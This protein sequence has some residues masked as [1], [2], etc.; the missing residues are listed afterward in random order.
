MVP[1]QMSY[2]FAYVALTL[3]NLAWLGCARVPLG[4]SAEDIT[5]ARDVAKPGATLFANECASCHGQRGEGLAGAPPVLGAG[6]LP[7]YPRTSGSYGQGD[8]TLTDPQ[9]LQIKAQTRPAGA[10]WRDP[11]KNAQDLYTFTTLHLPRTRASQLAEGDF[12]AIVSFIFAAQGVSLPPGGIGPANA[13]SL[14]MPK[15]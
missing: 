13:P 12:W 5:R 7:E 3:C 4:A 15:R 2:R 9:L 6:A 1:G 8:P 10:P 14:P 11:F